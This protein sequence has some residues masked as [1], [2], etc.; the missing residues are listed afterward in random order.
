MG[1]LTV[2]K[3]EQKYQEMISK[4]FSDPLPQNA[5]KWMNLI[6]NKS[7]DDLPVG[8]AVFDRGLFLQDCNKAYG[9]IAEKYYAKGIDKAK[10]KC[11]YEYMPGMH[12]YVGGVL[13]DTINSGN[14]RI[15][16]ER[17]I[18]LTIDGQVKETYWDAILIAQIQKNE[19]VNGLVIFCL[20]TTKEVNKQKR[21]KSFTVTQQKTIEE[22]KS[23][24]RVLNELRIEDEIKILENVH[25]NTSNFV[26]PLIDRL[27]VSSLTSEQEDL[28]TSIEN[29]LRTLT[30]SFSS[31]LASIDYNLTQKEIMI[32][33]LIKEGKTTK[34]IAIIL[35][36]S[37]TTIDFHRNNIRKKIGINRQSIGLRSYL[38]SLT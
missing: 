25:K 14:S 18:N 11:I 30:S 19:K 8:V 32:A 21:L 28:V 35:N 13:E 16:M 26:L 24:V 20:D 7:L 9:E 34:E 27:R 6:K 37:S 5:N 22:L 15:E 17:E 10:G 2:E 3:L 4:S 23:A 29:S 36:V 38:M 1:Q 31:Q 33:G 12:L